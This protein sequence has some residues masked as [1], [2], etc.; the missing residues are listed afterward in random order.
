M[1]YSLPDF[2]FPALKQTASKADIHTGRMPEAIIDFDLPEDSDT[3]S[4]RPPLGTLLTERGFVNQAQLAEALAVGTQT[5]AR[6][7]E[8]VVQRG[9][10]TED[11]V[12]K[13]LAEQWQ[14]GYVDRA[15]IFFDADALGR[16]SREE[17]QRLGALPTR[18]QDGHVVVA[19]AEPTEERLSALRAVIG[20]DT[21]VVVVPKTALDAGLRS[22]LLSSGN[23]EVTDEH[24]E[25]HEHHEPE[26][27]QEPEHHEEPDYR[28]SETPDQPQHSETAIVAVP[29]NT[30]HWQAEPSQGQ[31]PELDH[32]LAALQAT[33]AE[34]AALQASMGELAGRLAGLVQE[35]SAAAAALAHAAAISD[36]ERARIEQLEQQLAQRTEIT[37]SLKDQLAGLTRTLENY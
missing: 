1:P 27:H 16:L 37:D 33:A 26:H 19:V 20:E 18:I 10:A 4:G 28:V 17:A 29:E 34:A 7:G 2:G 3:E 32:V 25:P 9:W 21:L 36:E 11:D 8:I 6:L 13:L 23:G 5:G 31:H 35:A 24:H 30:D 12:A 15:S 14:L 22:D